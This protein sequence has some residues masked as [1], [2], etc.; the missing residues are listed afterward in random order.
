MILQIRQL[1][2]KGRAVPVL[3]IFS[4]NLSNF[5]GTGNVKR[6]NSRLRHNST[7]DGQRECLSIMS[8]DAQGLALREK[9]EELSDSGDE[10]YQHLIASIHLS[11]AD[12]Q[13]IP[14]ELCIGEDRW[15]VSILASGVYEFSFRDSQGKDRQARWVPSRRHG[16]DTSSIVSGAS[17]G[18]RSF[19]FSL[20]AP[21]GRRHPLIGRMDRAG[22]EVKHHFVLPDTPADPSI[23]SSPTMGSAATLEK[24]FQDCYFSNEHSAAKGVLNTSDRTR[25]LVVASGILVAVAEGWTQYTRQP[26]EQL[27]SPY[28][29]LAPGTPRKPGRSDTMHSTMSRFG[30]HRHTS[31]SPSIPDA[32]TVGQ[33]TILDEQVVSEINLETPMVDQSR[34]VTPCASAENLS[35]H[36][37]RHASLTRITLIQS[38][39]TPETVL[40]VDGEHRAQRPRSGLRDLFSKLQCG[41][42]NKKQQRLEGIQEGSSR[43]RSKSS[44]VHQNPSLMGKQGERRHRCLKFRK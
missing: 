18:E 42:G 34:R 37:S 26:E 12:G 1:G 9:I 19:K 33:A 21:T 32:A 27:E 17:L 30:R 40:G 28:P 25:L 8:L 31:T 10:D 5:G 20:L 35:T 6:R 15:A 16:P 24:H 41:G 3:E 29:P 11:T 2:S 38:S 22:I 14:S 23:T 36:V 7:K 43:A 39:P 13:Q 44:V 4:G